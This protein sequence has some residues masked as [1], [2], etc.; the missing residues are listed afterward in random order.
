MATPSS[1]L[2]W[3]IPWAE[4]PG[5]LH[6]LVAVAV[7]IW[8]FPGGA[9]GKE[10]ACQCRTLGFDPWVRRIPWRRKWQPIPVFL[11]GE[12][13]GQR[14]LADCSP[15]GRKRVGHDRSTEHSKIS[16]VQSNRSV[17]SLCA[18]SV[19]IVNPSLPI[20]PPRLPLLVLLYISGSVLSAFVGW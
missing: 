9:N 17:M 12:F 14:S 3:R 19:H 8:G 7:Y 13:H 20:S 11:P 4:E 10:P 6:G 5:G 18:R 1:I 2:A 15:W 16:P